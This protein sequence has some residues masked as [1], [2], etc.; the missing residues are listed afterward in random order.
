M[1]ALVVDM[2]AP[3]LRGDRCVGQACLIYS[4]TSRAG[5]KSIARIPLVGPFSDFRQIQRLSAIRLPLHECLPRARM[6]I[7]ALFEVVE[8]GQNAY[9]CRGYSVTRAN[10]L[11]GAINTRQDAA[12]E[13]TNA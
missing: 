9:L 12:R 7:F 5:S 4:V 8:T 11:T 10:P 6:G 2:V 3:Q 13:T 1:Q